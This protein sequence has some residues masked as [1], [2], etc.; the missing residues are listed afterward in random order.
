MRPPF[1]SFHPHPRPRPQHQNLQRPPNG[2]QYPM[3]SHQIGVTNPQLMSNP[4]TGH[5]NNL[6]PGMQLHPQFFNNHLSNMAQQQ[7]SLPCNNLNQLLPNLMGNLQFA[8]ANANLLGHSLPLLQQNLIQPLPPLDLSALASSQPQLNSFN[9]LSYPS[10]PTQNKN[11]NLQPP[12]VFS[13]PQSQ[14]Q[15]VNT[16][17]SNNGISSSKGNA[18]QNRFPENSKFRGHGQGSQRSHFDQADNVKRKFG[19]Y[20]DHKGKGQYNKMVSRPNGPDPT[21]SVKENKSS[22]ALVYTDKEIRQWREERR[23]NYPTK[24]NVEKKLKKISSDCNVDEEAKTRSQQ[25]KEILAKQAELG[26]EVAE[27]PSY[28]FSNTSEEVSKDK[29]D[30]GQF[31]RSQQV[32]NRHDRKGRFQSRNGKRRHGENDKFSKKPRFQDRNSAKESFVNTR[33]PTLLEKLLSADVRRDKH[34]LL[35]VFRFMVMNEFFKELPEQPLKLPLVLVEDHTGRDSSG[36]CK[37][38]ATDT[39]HEDQQNHID[40]D[41]DDDDDE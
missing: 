4:L 26:V 33:K 15:S 40:D 25:L 17:S 1:N 39:L 18:F 10:I 24:V 34:R 29:V 16:F 21:N 23:K 14:G 13:E 28:Y 2:F 19:F 35:Q 7:F 11:H 41:D 32:H 30:N 27:V 12:S 9:S 22:I 3:Q 38:T 20:K 37:D 8:V 36:L 6:I 5:L 31:V